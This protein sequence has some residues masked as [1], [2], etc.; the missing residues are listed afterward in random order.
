MVGSGDHYILVNYN[1][2]CT[3]PSVGLAILAILGSASAVVD[4]SVSFFSIFVCLKYDLKDVF[5]SLSLSHLYHDGR[6]CAQ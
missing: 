5:I 3:S 2:Y 4:V 6:K 1:M